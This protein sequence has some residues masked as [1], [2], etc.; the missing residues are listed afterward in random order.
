MC[1]SAIA[2]YI[3]GI[4]CLLNGGMQEAMAQVWERSSPIGTFPRQVCILRP[5]TLSINSVR[6]SWNAYTIA[7][8]F[9]TRLTTETF[10]VIYLPLLGPEVTAGLAAESLE[11]TPQGAGAFLTRDGVPR[12]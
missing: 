10:S 3:L 6:V 2:G 4:S 1:E 12:K 8:D 11:S 7:N 9:E 5:L